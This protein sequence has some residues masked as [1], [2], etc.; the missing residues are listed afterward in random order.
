[1]VSN[2]VRGKGPN[3]TILLDVHNLSWSPR[4]SNI[5]Q[6]RTLRNGTE[7]RIPFC[8][9]VGDRKSKWSIS[10]TKSQM[11]GLPGYL[12]GTKVYP[13]SRPVVHRVYKDYNLGM[14]PS[15][16]RPDLLSVHHM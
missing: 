1:M 15:V 13:L 6:F 3:G 4:A 12:F 16:P 14:S 8:D 11:R 7:L 10:G 2:S 9:N 5:V